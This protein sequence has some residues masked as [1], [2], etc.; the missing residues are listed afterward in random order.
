MLDTIREYASERL[1]TSD[2]ADEI[3]RRH[4]HYFLGVAERA[5]LNAGGRTGGQQLEIA[6]VD[7]DNFR[8]ALAWAVRA[9]EAELALRLATAL[10]QFWVADDPFEGVRW[11]AR[12]LACGDVSKETRAHGLRA[13]G[14]A[15]HIGGDAQGAQA[16]WAQ[17]LALF[18]ELDDD[19]GRAVLLHRLSI[20]AMVLGDPDRAHELVHASHEL[21][22]LSDDPAQRAWG[23]A[24]T[25]ATLGALARDGGDDSIAAELFS[26]SVQLAQEVDVDWWRGGVLAELS[27]LALR[28]NELATAE[29]LGRESLE[30]ADRLGD[31]SGRIFGV[32]LLASAA[33]ERGD[34]ERAGRL[35]GAIEHDQAFAPL[36][37]WVR[38]HGDCEARVQRHAGEQ[39]EAGLAA[40]RDLELDD[41]V[42]EALG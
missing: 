27:A 31:R 22:G 39:L 11:F 29:R 32:G 21:H 3:H 24:Q 23:H 15:T 19:H 37:G 14:S 10:E 40:G 33:A 17:S 9:E 1:E 12:I 2:E 26:E 30:L 5:N 34:L 28:Q 42:R 38:H 8:G 36:G 16:L 25:T 4:A 7:Q 41:A 20:S 18:E 35:W 13:W 6:F